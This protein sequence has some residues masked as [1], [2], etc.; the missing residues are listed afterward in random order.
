M[1]YRKGGSI[2]NGWADVLSW[3]AEFEL[4]VS[5]INV[6]AITKNI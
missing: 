3:T 5:R 4:A 6:A 2:L 1:K